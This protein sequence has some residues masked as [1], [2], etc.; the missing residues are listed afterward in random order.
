MDFEQIIQQV[1]NIIQEQN[2]IIAMILEFLP[3]LATVQTDT[4]LIVIQVTD[5]IQ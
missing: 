2:A 3:F 5:I 4:V 1:M